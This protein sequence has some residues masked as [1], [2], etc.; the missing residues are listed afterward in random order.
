MYIKKCVA[1]MFGVMLTVSVKLY[2]F[3]KGKMIV[4]IDGLSIILY[5]N[6]PVHC[7]IIL[8]AVCNIM[9]KKKK[10]DFNI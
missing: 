7:R 6:I 3:P 10:I 9:N 5:H 8:C 2:K 1:D 4:N